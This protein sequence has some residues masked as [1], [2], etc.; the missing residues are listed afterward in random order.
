MADH[1]PGY[2][3]LG[4]A[5]VPPVPLFFQKNDMNKTG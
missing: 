3:I 1:L 5:A 4:D 2:L